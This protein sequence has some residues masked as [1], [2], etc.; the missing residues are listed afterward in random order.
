MFSLSEIRSQLFHLECDSRR[1][2]GM[3]FLRYTEHYE[4][5][6]NH[7]RDNK[8]TLVQ[9]QSAYCRDHLGSPDADWTYT[10]DWSGYNIPAYVIEKVH[11]LGIP[12]PNHY[13]SLMLGIYGMIQGATL[14]KD[15]YLIG[16]FKG[17][18]VS[19]LQHELTH[20][21]FYLDQDYNNS[22]RGLL[23]DNPVTSELSEALYRKGYPYKVAVDE[24]QAY[25]TTGD[26][27]MFDDLECQEGITDLRNRLVPLHMKYFPRFM[28]K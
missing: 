20:A 27:G 14:G 10:S 18:E 5:K 4:S 9:Q 24:I 13:D 12:D 26:A 11:S 2:L 21:M 1:E 3:L 17:T 23:F 8:F 7:I 16:T 15:A 28:G 19:T 25:L 22:V 6:Y